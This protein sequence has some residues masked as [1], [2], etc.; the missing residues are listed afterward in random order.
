MTGDP[1]FGFTIALP[2]EVAFL[3]IARHVITVLAGL[4]IES[5]EV[6]P[7][8]VTFTIR[9]ERTEVLRKMLPEVIRSVNYGVSIELVPG[10]VPQTAP[11]P[12][13]V[14]Q[15]TPIPLPVKT[16]P[17]RPGGKTCQDA[18]N[19]FD[20]AFG[21][22]LVPGTNT[23]WYIRL[24]QDSGLVARSIFDK[25]SDFYTVPPFLFIEDMNIGTADKNK[26]MQA[27]TEP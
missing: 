6:S 19:V 21:R 8:S 24:L 3:P 11:Q 17:L 10:S 7:D 20:R 1:I 13:P 22:G 16:L 5:E 15:P 4:T 2:P 26:L 14:P 25:R 12:T 18:I 27:V 23:T 9:G